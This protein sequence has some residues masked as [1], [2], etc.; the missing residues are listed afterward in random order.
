[1]ERDLAGGYCSPEERKLID[2]VGSLAL[3]THSHL[4]NKNYSK[5][6]SKLGREVSGQELEYMWLLLAV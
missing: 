1:M 3:V 2:A 6:L 5:E 4:E